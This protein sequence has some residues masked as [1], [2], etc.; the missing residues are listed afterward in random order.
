MKDGLKI[1]DVT[2]KNEDDVTVLKGTAEVEQPITAYV[3]TGQG[4]AEVGMG[5]DLYKSSAVRYK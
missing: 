4:S 2:I 3:F 5:M 1:V